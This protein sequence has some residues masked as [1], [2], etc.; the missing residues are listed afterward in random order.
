M[1]IRKITQAEWLPEV[2]KCIQGGLHKILY[3]TT[4]APVVIVHRRTHRVLS[5]N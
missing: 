4:D 2:T 5:P 3:G 1:E